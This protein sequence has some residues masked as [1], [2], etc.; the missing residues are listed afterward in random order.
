MQETREAHPGRILEIELMKAVAIIG[1]VFVHAFE[2]GVNLS[3]PSSGEYAAAFLMEFLGAIPSAGVFM[4]AMGWGAAFSKRATVQ[5]Y[6]KRGVSLFVLGVVINLFEEYLPAILVPDALGPLGE[7]LPSILATDIYFFAALASLYFALMKALEE[8]K[9]LRILVSAL[10]VSLC[11]CANIFIGFES[12]TTGNEWLDTLLGLF[13]RV[14]EYSYFPFV[15]WI[16]FPVLGFGVASLCRIIGKKKL[17]LFAALTGTVALIA[18]S[19]AV[20]A[21]G[22][23]D[24]TIVDVV[25]VREG[26]YY[27]LHPI[28]VAGYGII[29]VEFALT[30]LVLLATKNRLPGFMLTMSKNVAQIYIVQ[31]LAIG[32]LSPLL[33]MIENIWV[34]VGMGCLVLIISYLGGLLLKKTNWIRV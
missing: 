33:V 13:I 23:P 21:M 18:S 14:N 27:A 22:M 28:Y 19:V 15:S 2:M 31:W 17:V 24:A 10:L 3:Y 16:V 11:F 9:G 32:L 12:F 5:S 25:S 20:R 29:M 30:Y 7:V 6:L 34:N 4:F 8:R 26:V 1:M